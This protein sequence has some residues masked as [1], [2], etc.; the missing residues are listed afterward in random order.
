MK[1]LFTVL[2]SLLTLT[3]GAQS[4]LNLLGQLSY[5][6]E[7]SDIWGYAANNKE[8]ALVGLYSGLSIVDVTDPA[9]PIEVEYLNLP[10]SSAWWDIKVWGNRAYVINEGSGGMA[11]V[12]LSNLPTSASYTSWTLN[13]TLSTAHNIFIDENG[14]G[15]IVGAN[16][17]NGGAIMI[18]IA[19]NPANPSVVGSYTRRYVHD[20]F[21][22]G[23]TMWTAEVDN[24]EF[25]VVDISNKSN[26]VVMA[27]HPTTSSV[28]HNLWL[29]DDGNYLFTTDETSDAYIES[30]DVSDLQNITL[31]DLYQSSPGQNVVP[32]NVFMKGNFGIISYYRDGVV[33]FDATFPDNLIEV[34]NYDTSPSY[35]GDGF[36]GAWGVYPYLPSGNIIASD[37]EEGLYV[38]GP[39][40]Q[41]ACFLKGV[42]TDS[43]TGQPINAATVTL[44]GSGSATS[45]NSNGTYATGILTP[46]NYDV[47]VSKAGYQPELIL[48]VNLVRGVQRVVNV[49]LKP[50][51]NVNITI[52]VLDSA[53]QAPIP[54]AQVYLEGASVLTNGQTF[55]ADAN[56]IV[57]YNTPADYYTI[58]AGKWGHVTGGYTGIPTVATITFLLAEG[59]YDDFVF[60][61]N[62]T[63]TASASTGDWERGEPN[64]TTFNGDPSNPGADIAND[65]GREAYVTGNGGGQAGSDDID[66][67]TVVLTSPVMDLTTY[68]DPI[69]R[70]Y[71]WFYNDGGSGNPNDDMVVKIDNG[72]GPAVTLENVTISNPNWSYREYRL[73]DYITLTNNVTFIVEAS[74]NNPGHLVEAGLDGFWVRDSITPPMGPEAGFTASTIQICPGQSVNFT[75]TSSN[76][77][78]AWNWSFEGGTP[79]S[80]TQQ[81]PS[82]NYSIPG[83]YDVRLIVSNSLGADTIQFTNLI[84]VLPAPEFDL[85]ATE[86]ACYGDAN[87]SIV[88]LDTAGNGSFTGGINWSNGATDTIITGL[89]PGSYEVTVTNSGGCSTIDQVIL[90]EPDSL[91]ITTQ[92]TDEN[93]N[94]GDGSATVTVTGG[95]PPYQYE[96]ATGDT[97]ASITN[98]MAGAYP[99]TVTDANG[100]AL[101]T[102][103][104]VS[105]LI[106]GINEAVSPDLNI[107]PSPFY[108]HVTISLRGNTTG[109]ANLRIYDVNGRLQDSFEITGNGHVKWGANAPTGLYMIILETAGKQQATYKILKAE[110]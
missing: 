108:N 38:L 105:Q 45:S 109:M 19:A 26:P 31:L 22:R 36:N 102:T 53:T 71:Q 96:W 99:V 30:Y 57:T 14:I 10:G 3:A 87:G 63:E 76:S 95:T 5:N 11:I 75:D 72:S 110:R 92:T 83:T 8:Y 73:T 79:I 74:D 6:E 28:T 42:V 16:L 37:I 41:Q 1:H 34:G 90:G 12:D 46:G 89:A 24:G 82:V 85:A 100:C 70:F 84:E 66:D 106:T 44:Q 13:G 29:S 35:S 25:S 55:T 17:A 40:Y 2:I 98:I 15:Y 58:Y 101:Q 97:A 7:L 77:P 64:G 43:V 21:V 23:D 67:G 62:W 68:N 50:V 9:N 94:D 61:F 59:Y 27:S 39:N 52:E 107:S 51:A 81:N 60:D 104:T 80:S 18:D 56:G 69:L 91:N 32:H 65:F 54:F 47:L 49:K 103:A 88:L 20:I 86:P 93:N 78:S 48:G 33:V 4:N